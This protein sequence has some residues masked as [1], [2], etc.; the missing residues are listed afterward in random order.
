MNRP[1]ATSA[2][3]LIL[4]AGPTLADVTP[5][6]VWQSL[7][8]SYEQ[9]GYEVQVGSEDASDEAISLTDVVLTVDGEADAPDMVLTLPQIVLTAVGDG[10]VRSVVDGQ[11]TLESSA[12]PDGDSEAVG[13]SMTLDAPGN[14][15]ISSGTPEALTHDIVMPTLTMA[16]RAMDDQNEVP[17]T[18]SLSGVTGSQTVTTAPDGAS[19]QTFEGRADT[20]EAQVTASGPSP[21]AAQTPATDMPE[22]ADTPAETAET[23]DFQATISIA[24]LTM[25]GDGT[26]PA[27]EVNFS[28][29]PTQALQAGFGGK[30]SFGMGATTGSFSASTLTADGERNDSQGSFDAAG[31][32]LAVAMSAEGLSY[33]GSMTDMAT[34]LTATDLP[35]PIAYAAAENRFRLA[36]PIV[37]SDQEQS[38][39]LTYVLDGLTMDDAI[40]QAMDPEA[41]LPRDPASLTIDLEGTALLTQNFMDPDFPQQAEP[42]PDGA[43]PMPLQ[44]RNL[45]IKELALDAVGA[46]ANLTGALTFGDDPSQ[47]VGQIEG[48][49]GGINGLLDTLVAMGVVPQEQLMGPRMMMAMFARPVE[50]NPDQLQTE[51][52]F[53]EGGAI[54]ANGQ[55]IQ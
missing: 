31:G 39:A 34:T 17:L 48:T 24:D 19:T 10:T 25:Q 38:F 2:I 9:M 36:M 37:A 55:Q 45:T 53:R 3:A 4:G 13:F 54:F 42:G 11:M 26:S 30:G 15:T 41:A 46:T 47:P 14:E 44:P 12:M 27:G 52:E 16:G 22:A 23:D 51:I 28:N 43:A 50:G 49:F 40:W 18:A 32:T 33:E 8:D 5:A 29:Q 7:Q 6:Q 1:L 20:L 21:A 35:F